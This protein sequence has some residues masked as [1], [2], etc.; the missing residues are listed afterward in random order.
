ME[1]LLD[2]G[3]VVLHPFVIGELSL[4]YLDPRSAILNML[5]RLPQADVA[6]ND[7][8]LQ[9]ID[10][11]ALFGTGIGYVDAHLLTSTVL[12]FSAFWTRDKRLRSIAEKLGISA[13]GLK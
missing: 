4:G 12:T 2:G 10:R 7:E 9:F 11:Y 6:T 13:N 1:R 8:A 3:E 5:R